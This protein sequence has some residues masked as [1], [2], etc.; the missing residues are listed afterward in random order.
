MGIEIG[1][2][3]GRMELTIALNFSILKYL[4]SLT[5]LNMAKTVKAY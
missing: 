2:A 1:V 3:V 5:I 4:F